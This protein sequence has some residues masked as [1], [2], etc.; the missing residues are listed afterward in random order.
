MKVPGFLLRRLY[1]K[2][3]L[4]NTPKGFQFQLRNHLGSGYARK[5][6]PVTVDGRELD[7]EATTFEAD[8]KQISFAQVSQEVPF[9]LAVNKT[10]TIRVEG[11]TLASGPHKVGM[12][13]EVAGL[14]AL[15][16]DFTDI[17]SND[18]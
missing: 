6:F 15:G 1:V 17:P 7:M 14:G 9:P 12:R 13:F 2:S 10:T 11:T 18:G 8:G 5:L 3:S 16:F 4:Q